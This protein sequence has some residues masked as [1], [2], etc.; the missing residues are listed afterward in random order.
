MDIEECSVGRMKDDQ[1]VMVTGLTTKRKYVGMTTIILDE[2]S[3]EFMN[4]APVPSNRSPLL[5]FFFLFC[6]DAPVVR[7]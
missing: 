6:P 4:K 1:G 7:T 2:D 3:L 5:F